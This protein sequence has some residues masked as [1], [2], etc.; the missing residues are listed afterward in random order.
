MSKKIKLQLKDIRSREQESS[1]ELQKDKIVNQKF[2][3]RVHYLM[4][5][6]E[7]LKLSESKLKHKIE[8]LKSQLN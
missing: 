5:T 3:E 2:E 4:E 6:N 8:D 7:L 1:F